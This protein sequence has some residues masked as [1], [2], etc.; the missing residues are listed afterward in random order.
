M[1]DKKPDFEKLYNKLL[2]KHEGWKA[3]DAAKTGKRLRDMETQVKNLDWEKTMKRKR[4]GAVKKK[5]KSEKKKP[6][7]GKGGH[8]R[9]VG[10]PRRDQ[11]THDM[12]VEEDDEEVSDEEKDAEDNSEEEGDEDDEI[13]KLPAKKKV[14]REGRKV[15]P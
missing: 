11:V 15:N 10:K 7:G 5:G 6:V 9:P 2:K 14:R 1:D 4:A 3:K 13:K 12:E 8:A